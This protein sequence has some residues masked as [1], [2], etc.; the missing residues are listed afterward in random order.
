MQQ[1]TRK[2]HKKVEEL[3]QIMSRRLLKA[4][5]IPA[6]IVSWLAGGTMLAL[7]TGLM[8]NALDARK[9]YL[10]CSTHGLDHLCRSS[11]QIVPR[12]QRSSIWKSLSLPQRSPNPTDDCY[13]RHGYRSSVYLII[14]WPPAD[15]WRLELPCLLALRLKLN[16]ISQRQLLILF[17]E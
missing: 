2:D 4:I 12:R 7:N 17:S 8:K 13:R 3:L 14:H 5:T 10:C 9:A 11:G 15:L 6:M 1:R 16:L